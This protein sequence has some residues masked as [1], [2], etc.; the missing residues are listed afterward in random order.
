MGAGL[1][2][3][4]ATLS[5]TIP[6]DGPPAYAA[7]I[8]PSASAAAQSAKATEAKRLATAGKRGKPA[9]VK[10]PQAAAAEAKQA[11][12]ELMNKAE[13][14][15]ND[16]A[17]ILARSDP[18]QSRVG[19]TANQLQEKADARLAKELKKV[20]RQGKADR[21]LAKQLQRATAATEDPYFSME[22]EQQSVTK[23]R[24][25][26]GKSG[27]DIAAKQARIEARRQSDAKLQRHMQ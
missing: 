2:M 15:A 23:P 12:A 26:L 9:Q 25:R 10:A 17:G 18:Y 1:M 19:F 13:Q 27:K 16:E 20:H 3:Y 5:K 8:A 24:T 4:G 21:K 22:A 14:I 6:K 7:R 11:Q